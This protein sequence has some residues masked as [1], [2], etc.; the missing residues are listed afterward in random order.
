MYRADDP[1]RCRYC[2]RSYDV[3]TD[4]DGQ[5]RAEHRH[6]HQ[7]QLAREQREAARSQERRAA[8]RNTPGQPLVVAVSSNTTS[9]AVTAREE[10]P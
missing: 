8:G 10:L 9:E 1:A 2:H 5:T 4:R 3:I 7:R 6:E